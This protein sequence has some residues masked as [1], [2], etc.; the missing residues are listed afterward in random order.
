MIWWLFRECQVSPKLSK[1]YVKYLKKSEAE[2]KH[3]VVELSFILGQY[4]HK[5]LI[6]FYSAESAALLPIHVLLH[7]LRDGKAFSS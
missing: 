5:F 2:K 4:A 1:K 7:F 6:S 3:A